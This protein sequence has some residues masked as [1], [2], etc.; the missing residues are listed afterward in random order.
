MER[1]CALFYPIIVLR[2]G[3]QGRFELFNKSLNLSKRCRLYS[4]ASVFM[5]CKETEADLGLLHLGYCS[6]PRS[7]SEERYNI[8]INR[9]S[10]DCE[11][12]DR[13]CILN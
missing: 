3:N 8:C 10:L 4:L 11:S 12:L 2:E 7:A 5:T 6:S 9:A 1:N 13:A